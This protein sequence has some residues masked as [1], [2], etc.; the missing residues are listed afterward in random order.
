[1]SNYRLPLILVLAAYLVLATLN[2]TTGHS[3]GDDF[4]AYILQARSLV[5]GNI[6]QNIE[7][8]RFTIEASTHVLGPVIYPWGF[9]LLIAPINAAVGLDLR[10][11]KILNILVYLLFLLTVNQVFVERLKPAQRLALIAALGFSP[12][13]LALHDHILSD[14]PYL[15][16][17]TLT[18]LWMDR[19]LKMMGTNSSSKLIAHIRQAA[20]L[21]L[22]CFTAYLLR[23]I[24]IVLCA[25]LLAA[26]ILNFVLLRYGNPPRRSGM[27]A[28][29]WLFLQALPYLVFGLLLVLYIDLFPTTVDDYINQLQQGDWWVRI[30]II[31]HYILLPSTIWHPW[32]EV[33]LP[34][35]LIGLPLLA[36]T[37]VGIWQT[38]RKDWLILVYCLINLVLLFSF[39]FYQGLRFI[40]PLL[41]FYLYFLLHGISAL[42]KSLVARFGVVWKRLPAT[43]YLGA[44]TVLLIQASLGSVI[45]PGSPAQVTGPFDLASQEMFQFIATQTSP[46]D[47][48]IFFKPRLMRLLTGRESFLGQT[49]ESLAKGNLLVLRRQDEPLQIST[50][51]LAACEIE[52]PTSQIFINSQF[53]IL[54]LQAGS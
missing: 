49:C 5:Q 13:L 2:L 34:N 48:V 6:E 14:L 54:R 51:D 38:W 11:Y 21:G 24:G 42:S 33:T 15:F 18:F 16:F 40:L 17:S 22:G 47:V 10:T 23:T 41:P 53:Q 46:D 4:A 8:N 30:K 9:P 1:M 36:L 19:W 27:P 37:A 7:S 35:L 28:A 12:A 20:V 52:K 29:G 32:A 25:T 31:G 44:A 39:P 45:N 50:E 26:Q 3:W 43:F